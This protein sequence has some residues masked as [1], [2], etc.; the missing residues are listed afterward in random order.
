[1]AGL[2]STLSKTA[3]KITD[4]NKADSKGIG[5]AVAGTGLSTA[6]QAMKK[7][8]AHR[9]RGIAAYKAHV[10]AGAD[11]KTNS[12]LKLDYVT[13][14]ASK[15]DG[16]GAIHVY[17]NGHRVWTPGAMQAQKDPTTGNVYYKTDTSAYDP[18]GVLK[19]K[20]GVGRFRQ[21]GQ[22]GFKKTSGSG[23]TATSTY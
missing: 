7:E 14:P 11:V 4:T 2:A 19:G 21:R 6:V 23:S 8:A 15:K 3:K 10:K 9:Q 12:K 18:S 22:K 5:T 17:E 16:G 1:M 20:A 13:V